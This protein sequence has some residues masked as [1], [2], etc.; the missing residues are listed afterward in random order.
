MGNDDEHQRLSGVYF[1][2]HLKANIMSLR[3]LDEGGCLIYIEHGFLK[4]CDHRQCLLTKV[5][6]TLS[7]LYIPELKI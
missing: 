5:W 3:Q 1:I 6:R 4:I 2:P 7:Q